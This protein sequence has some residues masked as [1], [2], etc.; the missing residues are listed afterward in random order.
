MSCPSSLSVRQRSLPLLTSSVSVLTDLLHL[1][2]DHHLWRGCCE[3]DSLL[4][5]LGL[6]GP[7]IHQVPH[8]LTLTIAGKAGRGWVTFT[9]SVHREVTS[10]V[11]GTIISL[12]SV[13]SEVI[14]SSSAILRLAIS[15]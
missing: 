1:L 14:F 4:Q 5:G 6:P 10:I 2:H 9:A 15:W 12:S 8:P 7:P 11:L 3:E 13:N